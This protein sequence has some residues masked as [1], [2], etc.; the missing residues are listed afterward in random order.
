MTEEVTLRDVMDGDLDIFFVQQQDPVAL[1]MAAFTAKEPAN[2]QVFIAHWSRIRADDAIMIQT[3]LY[4]GQVAGHVL[5][6][7]QFG[8]REVSYWLGR[9]YWGQGVATRALSLFLRLDE[10]R[11]LFARAAKDNAGSVR[12]LQKCGYVI[13]GEDKGYANARG[14]EVEEFILRLGAGK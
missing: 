4:G 3:I 13:A 5:S 11:P 10:T 8:K 6:F 12:V 1:H 7:E 14:E 2:K 9:E